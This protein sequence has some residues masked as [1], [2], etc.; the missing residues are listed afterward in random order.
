MSLTTA[1]AA[2]AAL[3]AGTAGAV[4]AY[5]MAAP[6]PAQTTAAVETH[7]RR[8]GADRP[9]YAPCKAPAKL[10]AGKC[11]TTVT[12]TVNVGGGTTTV[13]A[14]GGAPSAPAAPGGTA[15][16]LDDDARRDVDDHDL[17]V[18]EDHDDGDD[19]DSHAN[20]GTNTGTNTNT[21]AQGG[22]NTS[23]STRSGNG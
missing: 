3:A 17:E 7:Q 12:R 16:F 6:E 23:T 8:P 9:R 19:F 1:V 5:Q 11:V 22:T 10:E 13:P 18:V 2:V 21:G 20:T 4:T 14:E 15:P